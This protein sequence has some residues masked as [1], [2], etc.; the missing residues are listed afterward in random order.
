MTQA[1]DTLKDLVR[2]IL[3]TKI[4]NLATSQDGFLRLCTPYFNGEAVVKGLD[5]ATSAGFTEKTGVGAPAPVDVR[6]FSNQSNPKPYEKSHRFEAHRLLDLPSL[7]TEIAAQCWDQ[8][9][10]AI[11]RQFFSLL[12]NCTTTAHPENGVSG[13]PY[14]AYGGGTV[15]A[16]DDY[17]MTFLD[18]TTGRQQN[19]FTYALGSAGISTLFAKAHTYKSLSGKADIARPQPPI[20]ACH[21]DL[22]TLAKDLVAQKGRF[23]TGS[24]AESGFNGRI[25][26]VIKAPGDVA[27]IAAD[28]WLLAW[29]S[30]RT[31]PA[32]AAVKVGPVQVHIRETPSVIIEKIPAAADY[33]VYSSFNFDCWY[34]S[35]VDQLLFYSE[36]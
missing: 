9:W 18:G 17:S 28:A 23:Y 33:N 16:G 6:S 7:A 26:D 30:E 13:S 2:Q 19:A 24:G 11:N 36:P 10:N 3:I 20:L 5:I 34:T 22:E 1:L 35:T 27:G 4:A 31:T 8:A 29:V 25:Q 12:F 32:G 14:A 15:Y 21:A